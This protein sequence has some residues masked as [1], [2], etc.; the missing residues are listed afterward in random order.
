MRHGH[1]SERQSGLLRRW[2]CTR[3]EARRV[4]LSMC[5]PRRGRSGRFNMIN[6]HLSSSS[7]ANHLSPSSTAKL[8][9][10]S[11]IVWQVN[12]LCLCCDRPPIVT[13]TGWPLDASIPERQNLYYSE[14]MHLIC[15]LGLD[16][17][18]AESQPT[19]PNEVSQVITHL[20][21]LECETP[22][23]KNASHT[24]NT[25]KPAPPSNKTSNI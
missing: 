11:T 4:Y 15:R 21:R 23:P 20:R 16:I 6:N 19:E 18:R 1:Y 25:E 5:K 24:S 13:V 7:I 2:G 10:R 14:V 12:L 9:Y 17:M 22:S 3:I 8:Y